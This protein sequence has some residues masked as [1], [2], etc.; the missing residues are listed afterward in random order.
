[1]T[2]EN[3]VHV[4]AVLVHDAWT[5]PGPRPDYHRQ[6]QDTLRRQWP[7]LANALDALDKEMTP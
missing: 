7:R 3:R 6:A 5:H 1:V 2:G 4:A